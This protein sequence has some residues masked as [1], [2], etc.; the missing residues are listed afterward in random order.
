MFGNYKTFVRSK[1][2]YAGIILDD[3]SEQDSNL[4]DS[5]QMRAA[6]IVTGAKRGTHHQFINN[7]LGWN[8]LGDRRGHSKLCFMHKIIHHKAPD[9][10]VNLIP[11]AVNVNTIIILEIATIYSSLLLGL[12]N[13]ENHCSQIASGSG[14]H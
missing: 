6:R 14:T 10:L 7:E 4:L 2:E 1:L 5:C 11:D 8:S 9:Y 12:K 13:L 3:C